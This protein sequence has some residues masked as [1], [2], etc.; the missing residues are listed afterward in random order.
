MLSREELGRRI[1]AARELEGIKQLEMTKRGKQHGVGI[2]DLARVERGDM[3]INPPRLQALSKV[4]KVPEWWF[5]APRKDLFKPAR[6][7]LSEVA[8]RVQ[9]IEARLELGEAATSEMLT[10]I[11]SLEGRSTRGASEGS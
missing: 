6:D 7:D 3:P 5:T 4:L 10:R 8:R 9:A 2:H 1:V 11:A